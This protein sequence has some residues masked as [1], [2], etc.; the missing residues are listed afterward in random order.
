[1]TELD[2]WMKDIVSNVFHSVGKWIISDV[3][4]HSITFSTRKLIGD[5]TFES[6]DLL[7]T[8]RTLNNCLRWIF[9]YS[10]R[11][12]KSM[13]FSEV[14]SNASFENVNDSLMR[15]F[16]I[17]TG[18]LSIDVYFQQNIPKVVSVCKNWA[19]LQFIIFHDPVKTK[20]LFIR[21]FENCRWNV[22][23][24][25]SLTNEQTKSFKQ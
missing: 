21:I 13:S 14:Y 1:M 23:F 22:M 15:M 2:H 20:K 5:L 17:Q 16:H 8:T 10:A 25:F 24:C 3:S 7:S 12:S 18:I 4:L 6:E 9:P 19:K 11:K